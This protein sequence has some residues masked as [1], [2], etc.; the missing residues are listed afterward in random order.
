MIEALA[1]NLWILITVVIPGF[2]TYGVWRILILLTHN[3]GLNLDMCMLELIDNSALVTLSIIIA[4]A[5]LQQAVAITIEA[6]LAKYAINNKEKYPNFFSLFCKRFA[7]MSSEKFDERTIRIIA[8]FFLS[9]NISIG[10]SFLL[11]Y[12]MLFEKMGLNEWIPISLI[13]FIIIVVITAIFRMYNAMW[14]IEACLKRKDEEKST[15]K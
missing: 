8:N 3:E 7:Y 4:V 9:T 6:A 14:S 10:L 15:K 12:F 5:L 2:F 1:K 13:V 11:I